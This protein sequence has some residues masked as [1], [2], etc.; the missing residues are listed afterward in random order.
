MKKKQALKSILGIPQEE[1]ATLLGISRG[2]L[3][4][5]ESGKRDLPLPALLELTHMLTYVQKA[6]TGSESHSLKIKETKQLQKQL[7]KDLQDTTYLHQ[8]TD[9]RLLIMEKLRQEGFCALQL[10]DYLFAK[11]DKKSTVMSEYIKNNALRQLEK[12][13]EVAIER[14]KIKKLTLE[15]RGQELER[16]IKSKQNEAPKD[17]V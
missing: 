3:S 7:E 6:A 8:R 15:Q 5:Y 9:K 13:S 17:F 1:L 16:R 4:M 12:N 11:G 2:H 14:L 10:A